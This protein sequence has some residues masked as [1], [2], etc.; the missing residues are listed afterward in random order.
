MVIM[1]NVIVNNNDFVTKD[2]AQGYIRIGDVFNKS[3]NTT[4]YFNPDRCYDT[5]LLILGGSG[6]GKK[7]YIANYLADAFN[8]K[9]SFVYIDYF[10]EDEYLLSLTKNK[11][12][13]DNLIVIDIEKDCNLISLGFGDVIKNEGNMYTEHNIIREFNRKT[14]MFLQLLDII[15]SEKE[16]SP[17]QKKYFYSA[18]FVCLASNTNSTLKD[19]FDCLI[20]R[21]C[22]EKAISQIPSNIC[23]Y[24]KDQIEHLLT[25]N[26]LG[27]R[28]N[29]ILDCSSNSNFSKI[30]ILIDKMN[31]IKQSP[32]L[33]T[34]FQN[35]NNKAVNF[36]EMLNSGK[37]FLI[38]VNSCLNEEEYVRDFL[39][40]FFF[41]K[42]LYA[43]KE[44]TCCTETQ[45][46]SENLNRVH[47]VLNQQLNHSQT[48]KSIIE[49]GL[50][51][52]VFGLKPVIVAS[53]I[54]QLGYD[55]EGIRKNINLTKI[56]RFNYMVLPGRLNEVCFDL[57]SDE[58][59]MYST[60]ELFS[61]EKYHSINIVNS[62][63][64]YK[65]F[66]TKLPRLEGILV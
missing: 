31:I 56:A 48:L 9:D 3:N 35:K 20:S 27:N 42:T 8:H 21:D 36:A 2:F 25:L 64:G 12:D 23:D 38:K 14:N 24:I 39:S 52:R 7:T 11:S 55:H 29:S 54:S 53:H 49:N 30:D 59:S 33:N 32:I 19:I 65:T 44:R 41:I 17:Y 13:N 40:T 51:L 43:C 66:V 22:R 6:S 46:K 10:N 28:T 47:F 16:L 37:S 62:S 50:K 18:S 57:F 63:C 61:I 5:G 26:I 4:L 58:L 34:I 15:P 1:N 45:S 60:N